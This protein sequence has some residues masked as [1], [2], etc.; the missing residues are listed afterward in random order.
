MITV[1]PLSPCA[2]AESWRFCSTL[3]N[4]DRYGYSPRIRILARLI[5]FS[6]YGHAKGMANHPVC[7]PRSAAAAL[8][9]L[10]WARAHDIRGQADSF[11][12]P[13]A[14]LRTLPCIP[15][16]AKPVQIPAS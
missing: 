15:P 11:W 3:H 12:R 8:A 2:T 9:I 7:G 1:V 14:E 6:S 10:H 13:S 16:P 4:H 5:F